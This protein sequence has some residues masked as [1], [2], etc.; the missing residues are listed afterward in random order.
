[1]DGYFRRGPV[2][3]QWGDL[4]PVMGHHRPL[5]DYWQAFIEA[6]FTVDGFEE[7]SITARGLQ[8]LPISRTD[9]SQ[10]I[11]YSCIFRLIK[12]CRADV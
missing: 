7:P 11:P 2:L 9:Y 3:T 5:H 8:E 1:M 10:R 6:G 12:P 4:D